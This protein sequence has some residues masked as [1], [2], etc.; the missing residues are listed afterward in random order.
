ME[1]DRSR[2]RAIL[3]LHIL[4]VEI[5]LALGPSSSRHGRGEGIERILVAWGMAKGNKRK[6]KKKKERKGNKEGDASIR[7]MARVK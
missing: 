4:F 1:I 2:Y 6:E 5:I 3:L 7:G